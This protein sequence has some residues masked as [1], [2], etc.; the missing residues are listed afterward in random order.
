LR[1]AFGFFT[2][3]VLRFEAGFFLTAFFEAGFF[4]T[5]RAVPAAGFL[6]DVEDFFF[7]IG[8]ALQ[9]CV[10]QSVPIRSRISDKG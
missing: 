3:A 1:D 6:R 7:A 4:F 9:K 10:R 2:A 5:A 8:R